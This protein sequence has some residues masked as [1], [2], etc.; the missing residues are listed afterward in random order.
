MQFAA[1]RLHE[2]AFES[3]D[4]MRWGFL[5]NDSLIEHVAFPVAVHAVMH[6]LFLQQRCVTTIFYISGTG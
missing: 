5:F 4:F 2:R 1:Y 3:N 6:N